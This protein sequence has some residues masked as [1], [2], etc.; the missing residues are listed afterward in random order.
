MY[1]NNCRFYTHPN[2]HFL[3]Y[4]LKIQ[5]R[6]PRAPAETTINLK[7]FICVVGHLKLKFRSFSAHVRIDNALFA[8]VVCFR[9]N[10][11]NQAIFEAFR[12]RINAKMFIYRL[13][14][15]PKSDY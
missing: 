15:L 6:L 7:I 3:M 10:A 4:P 8:N 5:A 1:R 2:L 11:D 13:E 9:E 12:N 14:C